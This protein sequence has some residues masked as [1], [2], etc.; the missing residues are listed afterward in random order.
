MEPARTRYELEKTLAYLVDVAMI[1]FGCR[2]C[3]D[4]V[5]AEEGDRACLVAIG[6]EE[7]VREIKPGM[8][9]YE[10]EELSIDIYPGELRNM[11]DLV[12]AYEQPDYDFVPTQWL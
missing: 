7:N 3:I 6:P 1:R 12:D 11:I 5:P 10:Q 8:E 4:I 2:P 9:A